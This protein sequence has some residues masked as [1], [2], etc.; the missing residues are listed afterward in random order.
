MTPQFQLVG[1]SAIDPAGEDRRDEPKLLYPEALMRA[2]Q[3][4]FEGIAFRVYFHGEPTGE[5]KQAFV[6]LGAV[7]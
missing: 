3:L 1:L 7:I 5:Q 4:K 2:Q 6:D